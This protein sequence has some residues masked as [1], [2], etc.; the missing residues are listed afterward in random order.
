M[1]NALLALGL[2][3]PAAS[4]EP[5]RTTAGATVGAT[6]DAELVLRGSLDLGV[7]RGLALTGELGSLP[8]FGSVGL[9]GGPLFEV[10]DGKWWRVGVAAMP[11]LVVPL[12]RSTPAFAGRGGLRVGWLAFWG[13]SVVGRADVVKPLGEEPAWAELGLGLAVRL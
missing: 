6:P 4:A 3:L 12:D 8:G 7:V 9:A 1:I 10:V 11:E 13:A 5:W 2:A